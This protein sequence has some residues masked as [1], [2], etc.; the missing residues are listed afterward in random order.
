VRLVADISHFQSFSIHHDVLNTAAVEIN[1]EV[2]V[3]NIGQA[4]QPERYGHYALIGIALHQAQDQPVVD[5]AKMV[6]VSYL[7]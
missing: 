7:P 2:C 5:I 1:R 3:V 4:L 6:E